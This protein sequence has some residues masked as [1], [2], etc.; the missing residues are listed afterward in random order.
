VSLS[1]LHVPRFERGEDEGRTEHEMG[2]SSCS[3]VLRGKACEEDGRRKVKYNEVRCSI[4]QLIARHISWE[5]GFE[6]TR[7]R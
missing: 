2:M 3:C 1:G 7:H 4:C 6:R 5:P